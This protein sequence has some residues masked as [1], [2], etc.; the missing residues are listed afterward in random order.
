[1]EVLLTLKN[2]LILQQ[3]ELRPRGRP[4]VIQ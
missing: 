4:D 1:M 2:L 3:N